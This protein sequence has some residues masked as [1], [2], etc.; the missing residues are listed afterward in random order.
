MRVALAHYSCVLRRRIIVVFAHYS[1]VSQEID[2]QLAAED[3]EESSFLAKFGDL[4]KLFAVS[5]PG[6]HVVCRV[7]A[8]RDVVCC[9]VL[10]P[11]ATLSVAT[12]SS[13]LQRRRTRSCSRSSRRLTQKAMRLWTRSSSRSSTWHARRCNFATLH[14]LPRAARIRTDAGFAALA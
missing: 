8:C 7:V 6:H 13:P 5:D 9:D 11:V 3:S 1:C 2:G 12:F 4:S 10:F 14:L